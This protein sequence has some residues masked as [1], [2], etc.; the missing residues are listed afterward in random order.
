MEIVTD[1]TLDLKRPNIN[2]IAH[3]KQGDK[4]SRYINAALV[5]GAQPWTPPAGTMTTVRFKKPDGHAGFYDVDENGDPAVVFTGNVAKITLAEQAITV[6]G[7][8]IVEL[9]MYNGDGERLS[10]FYFIVVVEE[11]ALTDAE[12]ESTDYFSILTVEIATVLAKID[13]VAGI[14]AEADSI[15]FGEETYVIVTGGT[16]ADDPYH[17]HFYIEGAKPMTAKGTYNSATTY[18]KLDF[19]L[20]NGSSYVAM[21]D[22]IRNVTPGTSVQDWQ[23]VAAAATVVVSSQD[24]KYAAQN[25]ADYTGTPPSSGWSSTIPE[26]GSGYYVWIRTITT[27]SDTSTSTAYSVTR[28]GRDGSA[29][30]KHAVN[31]SVPVSAWSSDETY[32]SFPYKALITNAAF[33]DIDSTDIPTVVLD[34][35]AVEL[36]IIAPVCAVDAINHGIIIYASDIPTAAITILTAYVTPADSGTVTISSDNVENKSNVDGE[37]VTEALNAQSSQIEEF[38]SLDT[39]HDG[40][41][42]SA[43]GIESATSGFT[44]SGFMGIVH[45]GD[46]ATVSFNAVTTFNLCVHAYNA[47]KEWMEQIF[48]QA[49]GTG[50][51]SRTFTVPTGCRYI[52]ISRRT[53]ATNVSLTVAGASPIPAIIPQFNGLS[54]ELSNEITRATTE[55]TALGNIIKNGILNQYVKINPFVVGTTIGT[56]TANRSTLSVLQDGSLKIVDAKTGTNTTY[57]FWARI[58]PADRRRHIL[59]IAIKGLYTDWSAEG[60][61]RMYVALSNS[62]STL[63]SKAYETTENGDHPFLVAIP[64]EMPDV[65]KNIEVTV[66]FQTT[67][68]SLV[69]QDATI[70]ALQVCDLTEKF[71][72]GFEPSLEVFEKIYPEIG[73]FNIPESY[74]SLKDIKA[75]T[76]DTAENYDPNGFSCDPVERELYRQDMLSCAASYLVHEKNCTCVVGTPTGI[77]TPFVG[78]YDQSKGYE[79]MYNDTNS[80]KFI[81]TDTQLF[82]GVEYPV[83][84]LDCT[85]FVGLLTKCIPYSESPMYYAFNH[86]PNPDYKTMFDLGFNNGTLADK[87]YT[88]DI[89]QYNS[90]GTNYSAF[91]AN[92]SGNRLYKLY[93]NKQ[94]D[95][96]VFSRMETGDILYTGGSRTD[97]YRGIHHIQI[98][99]KSLDELNEYGAAYGVTFKS[100]EK[101]AE[102]PAGAHGYVIDVGE[103]RDGYDCIRVISL[104]SYIACV[105]SENIWTH[106]ANATPF[107]SIKVSDWSFNVIDHALYL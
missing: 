28:N 44:A 81:Y 10:S 27:Y 16:G 92:H 107:N 63:V 29:T 30:I 83:V 13:S 96:K 72:E 25:A 40:Y 64:S 22:G 21:R 97:I 47:D 17:L 105:P 80:S 43:T 73:E 55:E 56:V 103:E 42:I 88:F 62:S 89:H 45:D 51:Y 34:P 86:L 54:N 57:G 18:N 87:P 24:I 41:A 60:M 65:T 67:S 33:D 36:G 93:S 15:P 26:S 77:D 20:Y 53:D 101:F 59:Y 12:I 79:C 6:P 52:R 11:S 23:L 99:L 58:K 91:F 46:S 95:E 82:D 7:N 98:F 3:A 74:N 102:D 31:I 66:L 1:L 38:Y 14:E 68:S 94:V 100:S 35:A 71:G 32:E 78:I 49:T 90:Q 104:D 70:D 84:Y 4:L 2:T 75:I 48:T 50:A 69:G 9:T 61:R 37:T 85:A 76:L 5:D 8:V 39:D 106:K 19:V